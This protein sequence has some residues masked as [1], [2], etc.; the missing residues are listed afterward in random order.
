MVDTCSSLQRDRVRG[1]VYNRGTK[2][3]RA[4]NPAFCRA[5]LFLVPI[6]QQTKGSCQIRRLENANMAAPWPTALHGYVGG[7]EVVG[8]STSL[9]MCRGTKEEANGDKTKQRSLFVC[10]IL[11]LHWQSDLS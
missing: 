5:P 4:E 7:R 2:I 10:W 3:I 9:L 8:H 11:L 1:D 6:R